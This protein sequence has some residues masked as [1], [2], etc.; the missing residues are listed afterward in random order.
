MFSSFGVTWWCLH[1]TSLIN[2]DKGFNIEFCSFCFWKFIETF[3]HLF[4]ALHL[5]NLGKRKCDIFIC[6][7]NNATCKFW[8]AFVTGWNESQQK[9]INT[10]RWEAIKPRTRMRG[11]AFVVTVAKKCKERLE[12]SSGRLVLV[13]LHHPPPTPPHKTPAPPFPGWGWGAQKRKKKRKST[14]RKGI[15]LHQKHLSFE[16]IFWSYSLNSLV[17]NGC[18]IVP[19]S[20][21][22]N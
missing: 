19:Q 12:Q 7:Q 21:L 10:Y 2:V 8:S 20:K 16:Q 4:N 22:Q 13:A 17:K 14:K 3:S 1:I 5:I 6:I 9:N 15:K 11:R 18:W